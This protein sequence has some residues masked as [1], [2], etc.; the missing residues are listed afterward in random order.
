[1]FKF[2]FQ[3]AL[4]EDNIGVSEAYII[5]KDFVKE[6][7]K[8]PA[9]S[10]FSSEYSFKQISN[11]EF[12]IKSEVNSENSFGAKLRSNWVVKLKYNDGDWTDK[13]NWVLKNIEIY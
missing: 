8:S 10:D 9:T 7:L 13:N 6:N 1:M 2:R 4:A 3:P 11:K 5:S 12:E